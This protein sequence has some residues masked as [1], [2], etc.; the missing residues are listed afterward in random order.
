MENVL[1]QLGGNWNGCS[2]EVRQEKAVVVS[3][4]GE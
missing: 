3:V 1:R 4:K 2:G